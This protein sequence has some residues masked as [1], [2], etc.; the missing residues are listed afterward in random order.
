MGTLI[1]KA[2]A[3]IWDQLFPIDS[4]KGVITKLMTNLE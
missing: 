1:Y 4:Y 3:D 2:D